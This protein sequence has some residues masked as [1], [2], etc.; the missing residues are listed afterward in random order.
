MK[1]IAI[2]PAAGKGIRMNSD[3]KKQYLSLQSKP[4]LYWTLSAFENCEIIDEMILS[5][6]ADDVD[7]CK[8]E[9]VDKFSLAKVEKIVAGGKRRQDSVANGF[10]AIDGHCDVVCIHDAVRP[11]ISDVLIQKSVRTAKHFGGACVAVRVTDTIKQITDDG[12][13]QNTPIRRY[14][15]SA[16]TPQSFDYNLYA[17]ALANA[18]KSYIEATDDSA[19]VEAIGG[20]VVIIEGS[21]ENIKITTQADMEFAEKFLAE[22]SA[23][24]LH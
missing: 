13:I 17:D 24:S 15:Y 6:P 18:K 14:L 11:L 2:I 10:E 8:T 5:V 4:I 23:S 9:I 16:Q 7:Y 22:R 12:F 20:R 19:L 21:Y 1:T 3:T